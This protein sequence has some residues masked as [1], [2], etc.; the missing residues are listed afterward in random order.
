MTDWLQIQRGE[1]PLIVALPHTGTEIPAD[2]A[3][4]LRDPWLA[5]KDTDWHVEKLYQF[6]AGLGATIVRT[7]VS[8]SVI[9][10][11]RD[12]SGASLYPGQATTDLCP[13]TSFDGEPLYERGEE[14]NPAEI[15]RRREAYFEPYH[16]ALEQQIELLKQRHGSIVLYDAHA[17]RSVIPRLFDGVLPD[18]NL[19]TD[20][21][22]TCDCQLQKALESICG[23]SEFSMVSNGRFR[24]GWTTRHYGAPGSGIHAVQMELA[25]RCFLD[26]P[27]DVLARGNWPPPFNPQRATR[28]I[29]LLEELLK[30]AIAFA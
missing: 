11:N 2:I 24:G 30:A 10:V 20:N 3:R 25:C 17:I 1:A 8:R 21:G 6:A 29:P 18:L 19:G 15:T 4:A 23:R 14:P 27:T 26:E 5:Q 13:L 12:P 16:L 7:T 28:L 9:D 22:R